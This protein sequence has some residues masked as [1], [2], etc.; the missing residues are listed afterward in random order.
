[1]PDAAWKQLE[2][3]LAELIGGGR[4]PANSGYTV[5]CGPDPRHPDCRFFAQAK[6]V[7]KMSLE[8]ITSLAETIHAEAA[9]R[10]KLGIVGVKVR[11]GKGV[12][13]PI[14]V[15]MTEETFKVLVG[16]T[17]ADGSTG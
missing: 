5:D 11:R 17:Q 15:V 8:E 1:M 12:K 7:K 9:K 14:L 2:R 3:A 13:S 6:L 10:G 16:Y 4:Y